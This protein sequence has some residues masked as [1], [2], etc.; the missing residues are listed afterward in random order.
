MCLLDVGS[1]SSDAL[2]AES[3]AALLAV[4]FAADVCPFNM[5]F[6]GDCLQVMKA[7]SST[8]YDCS[9]HKKKYLCFS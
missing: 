5:I 3:L 1:E 9:R 6:E 8:K 2:D 7:L 4:E